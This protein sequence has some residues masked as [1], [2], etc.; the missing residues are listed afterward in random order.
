MDR[1]RTEKWIEKFDE[2]QQAEI[3]FAQLYASEF[4]HGTD[5]H[6]AK[7]IIAK[8]AQMLTEAENGR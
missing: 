1:E 4:H 3:R 7:I 5:G 2:R 6:N 8:M